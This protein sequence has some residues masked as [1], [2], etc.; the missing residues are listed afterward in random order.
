MHDN[1]LTYVKEQCHETGPPKRIIVLGTSGC[2]EG[3]LTNTVLKSRRD[4]GEEKDLFMQA[5]NMIGKPREQLTFLITET[6]YIEPHM[7]GKQ[8]E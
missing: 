8:R 5:P 2:R 4:I 3:R 1:V 7:R 6:Y